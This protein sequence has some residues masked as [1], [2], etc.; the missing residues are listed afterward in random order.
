MI[1]FIADIVNQ[2]L[3]KITGSHAAMVYHYKTSINSIYGFR[4]QSP[5]EIWKM[6]SWPLAKDRVSCPRNV[7]EVS[8]MFPSCLFVVLMINL[9]VQVP[10]CSD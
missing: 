1:V 3:T 9:R 6:I 2:A 5:K 8:S 10:I 4:T 7:R